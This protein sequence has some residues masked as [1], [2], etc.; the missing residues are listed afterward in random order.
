LKPPA[1]RMR[2]TRLRRQIEGGTLIGTHGT[3]F[4]GGAEKIAEATKKRKK[5]LLPSYNE[6]GLTEKRNEVATE[7]PEKHIKF[8]Y[9]ESSD[10]WETSSGYSESDDEMP[11]A[12][13]VPRIDADFPAAVSGVASAG[14]QQSPVFSRATS[15]ICSS[16]E[17]EPLSHYHPTLLPYDN[18]LNSPIRMEQQASLCTPQNDSA[19]QF[20]V[21]RVSN[22]D[23]FERLEASPY[24]TSCQPRSKDTVLHSKTL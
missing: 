17:A 24:I 6:G 13:R 5:P 4:G 2:Y 18:F 23:Q 1:A 21:P 3:P 12:K 15:K 8:E 19:I 7:D 16:S 14:H 20:G 9:N 10:M 22:S 11:L